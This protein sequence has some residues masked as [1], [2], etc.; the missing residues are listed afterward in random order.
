MIKVKTY[1]K[2]GK[3]SGDME[4]PEEVFGLKIKD[5]L[6]H[7]AYIAHISN[8][9]Q[10]L[11]DTKDKGEVSGGGRKPWKQ[12]GTGRA[13]HGSNRSPIWKGGGV[14][15]GPT[16]LRNYSKK[17]NKKMKKKALLMVLSSK[18]RDNELVI[19]DNFKFEKI[20]TKSM[21]G[22]LNNLPIKGKILLSLNKKD[23]NALKSI[24]NI[25]N[26]NVIASDSLNIADLLK[27]KTLVINKEG[28]EKIKDTFINVK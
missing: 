20:S 4:L 17:I 3:E 7:Q 27:N 12:K 13:R 26:V 22:V 19:I 28:I 1:N 11:A 25:S 8:S 23:N 15:F 2:E 14:T 21:N 24:E 9:R 16:S 10:V 6:V 18:V 5:D